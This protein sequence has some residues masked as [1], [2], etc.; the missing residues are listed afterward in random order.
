M[1]NTSRM[2]IVVARVAN[3]KGLAMTG[4][5][6]L[7]PLRLLNSSQPQL[8]SLICGVTQRATFAGT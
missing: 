8:A 1:P 6:H 3:D 7:D 5:H 2:D 4:Y